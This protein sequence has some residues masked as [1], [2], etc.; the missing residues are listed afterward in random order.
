ML[1]GEQLGMRNQAVEA[2]ANLNLDVMEDDI[3]D[4]AVQVFM[5]LTCVDARMEQQANQT[6]WAFQSAG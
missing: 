5:P 6:P 1:P 2:D 3:G 4:A